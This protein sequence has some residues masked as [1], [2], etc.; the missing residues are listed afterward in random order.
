MDMNYTIHMIKTGDHVAWKWVNG[1]AE[2]IVKSVHYEP[3]VITSNG[4]RIKRNGNVDNPAVV[5]AHK[6]GNDVIKLVSEIQKTD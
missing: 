4:K 1:I 2:G 3:I 6:S 5:I